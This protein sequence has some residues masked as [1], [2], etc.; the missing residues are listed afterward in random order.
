M[1]NQKTLALQQD[2]QNFQYIQSIVKKK[3]PETTTQ[4]QYSLVH[5][6]MVI[7][8]GHSENFNARNVF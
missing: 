2:L 6:M 3:R 4:L 5:I 8:L 7:C 1:L